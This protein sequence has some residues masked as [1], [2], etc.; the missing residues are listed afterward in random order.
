[1]DGALE[2]RVKQALRSEIKKEH[3]MILVTHKYDMLDLVDRIIVLVN[4]KV[5]LDGD[6][7]AV[8]KKLNSDNKGESNGLA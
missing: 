5:V 6:R 8:I 3:T 2:A 7:D 4:N 1:M